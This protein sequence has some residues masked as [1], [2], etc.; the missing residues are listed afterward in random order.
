MNNSLLLSSDLTEERIHAEG[1][2]Q[3]FDLDP[4]EKYRHA[5]SGMIA[6][7]LGKEKKQSN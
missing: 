7:N 3:V 4:A 6:L 2:A 5:N 1:F